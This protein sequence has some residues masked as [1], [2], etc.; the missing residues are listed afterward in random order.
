MNKIPYWINFLHDSPS[1]TQI[2]LAHDFSFAYLPGDHTESTTTSCI[3]EPC[4]NATRGCSV[5]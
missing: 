5:I 1:I 2:T 4:P 3:I